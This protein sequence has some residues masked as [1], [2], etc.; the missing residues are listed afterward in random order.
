MSRPSHTPWFHHH[1]YVLWSVQ[2][3]KFLIMQFSAALHNFHPLRFKYFSR[4]PQRGHLNNFKYSS[5]ATLRVGCT[6]GICFGAVTPAASRTGDRI[7]AVCF[8]TKGLSLPICK[9]LCMNLGR[10]IGY[11]DWGFLRFSTVLQR[12]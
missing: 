8:N 7:S 10:A 3:M 2:V 11:A 12:I 5:F 9:V 4:H 1:N 6:S